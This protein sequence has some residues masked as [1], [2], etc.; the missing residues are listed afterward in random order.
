MIRTVVGLPALLLLLPALRA[1][2][3][4][5]KQT[6]A[7]QYQ[8]LE[9][10]YYTAQQ[11]Y[12]KALKEA[13]TPQDQQKV[14]QEKYPHPG[15]FASRFLELAEK[16]PKAPAAVDALAWIVRNVGE[17]I[18]DPESPR[19]KAVKILLRDHI[20]SEKMA[21]LC[22]WL[23]Y[24]QDEDSQKLLRAVLEKNKHRAAQGQACFALAQQVE[25][26]LRL[27]RQFKDQP[28]MAEQYKAFMGKEAVEKLVKADPD[29]LSKEAEALY[30]R[31]V[32]DFADVAGVADLRNGLLSEMAK[33]KL[34]TI[35]HPILVGK[36]APEIE[37]EDIDGKKFKLSDYRGKVVM[38]DFWGHW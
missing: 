13:K 21:T 25:N 24:F 17:S 20:Q 12:R 33:E 27:A 4:P 1:F 5:E 9:E 36:P 3:T 37:A 34:E 14:F 30:E 28:D 11:E 6:P 31:I 26:R 23:G 32:K 15:K 10:G 38:L 35:R 19:S 8:A 18:N 16:T 7:Q 2:D 22:Q 29:K